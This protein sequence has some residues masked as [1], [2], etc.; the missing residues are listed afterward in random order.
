MCVGRC[1]LSDG[2]WEQGWA[3]ILDRQGPGASC[4][5]C[6]Q[7]DVVR[8]HPGSAIISKSFPEPLFTI[9]RKRGEGVRAKAL[10]VQ[11]KC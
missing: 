11:V 4:E 9:I 10:G 3:W 5:C 7:N 2:E 1:S 8:C 6:E